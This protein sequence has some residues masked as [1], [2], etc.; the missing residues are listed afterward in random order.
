MRALWLC[1]DCDQ[2]VELDRHGRCDTCCSEAVVM[3]ERPTRGCVPIPPPSP[4][5]DKASQLRRLELVPKAAL[6]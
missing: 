1:I 2:G 6:S 3:L 4:I 5:L